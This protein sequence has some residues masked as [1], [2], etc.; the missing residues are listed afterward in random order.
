MHD[1]TEG[2]LTALHEIADNSG[3]GF[4]VYSERLPIDPL[5]RK[6]LDFYDLEPWSVSSTGTLIAI[7]PPENVNSLITEL[8]KNG[9]LAFELGGVHGR[10]G[11]GSG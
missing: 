9:I 11:Q 4:R 7:T 5:V 8:F 3:V 6:V 1:A 10:D 2:G